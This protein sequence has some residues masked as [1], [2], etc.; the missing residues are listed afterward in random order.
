MLLVDAAAVNPP[1]Y[2]PPAGQDRLTG[3]P[4]RFIVGT[5]PPPLTG[6]R[7]NVRIRPDDVPEDNP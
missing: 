7:T 6:I 3:D 1:R 2:R 4:D 5:I